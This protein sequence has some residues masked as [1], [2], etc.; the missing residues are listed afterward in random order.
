M[1]TPKELLAEIRKMVEDRIF[2]TKIREY[3]GYLCDKGKCDDDSE[4]GAEKFLERYKKYYK[5]LEVD[6]SKNK[7][8]YKELLLFHDFLN[9]EEKITPITSPFAIPD[10]VLHV[11]KK[12][13]KKIYDKIED[14]D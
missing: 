3:H 14:M 7:K 11:I 2:A 12:C 5:R 10:N 9:N 4:K 6:L 8:S 1:L 13:S